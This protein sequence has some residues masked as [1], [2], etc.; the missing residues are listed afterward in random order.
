[1]K[2]FYTIV[3]AAS[4]IVFGFAG[5]ASARGVKT[6][7]V[8]PAEIQAGTYTVI[9]AAVPAPVAI[10]K[11]EGAGYDIRL[12]TA[13]S[14]YT[15]TSGLSGDVALLKAT[16]VLE[17]DSSV[18]NVEITEIKSPE[19]SVIGYELTPV[20]MPLRYGSAGIAGD[21]TGTSYSVSKEKERVLAYVAPDTLFEAEQWGGG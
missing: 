19:G 7:V 17:K 14:G 15:V 8:K 3:F 20:Y 9:T 10:L 2:I 5:G 13:G 4:L 6:D 12:A 11:K 21:V 18:S 16:D 1:M